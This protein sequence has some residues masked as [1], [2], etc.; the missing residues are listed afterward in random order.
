MELRTYQTCAAAV[1][2]HGMAHQPLEYFALGLA[3]EAGELANIV[4]KAWRDN[5]FEAGEGV[6]D[7]QLQE[8]V[9]ELGDILWYAAAV[10]TRL[11]L[12]LNVVA[13]ANLNK[14]EARLAFQRALRADEEAFQRAL[15]AE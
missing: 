1:S 15:R 7:A 5:H 14:L 9:L 3:G 13:G 11:D 6:S 12:D 10:A 4:K 8:I 2:T